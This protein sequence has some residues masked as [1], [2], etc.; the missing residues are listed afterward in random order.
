MSWED[1]GRGG[2]VENRGVERKCHLHGGLFWLYFSGCC[3]WLCK[4]ISA[5]SHL[6]GSLGTHTHTLQ[7]SE[8]HPTL[9]S[10]LFQNNERKTKKERWCD[11]L[12]FL[13]CLAISNPRPPF[14]RLHRSNPPWS[15]IN[16]S[17]EGWRDEK[18]RNEC[19]SD[20][21][22]IRSEAQ[23]NSNHQG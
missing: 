22:F 19:I 11:S 1:G 10:S 16:E 3:L 13:I 23:L 7:C 12:A 14:A 2:G 8:C 21:A 18:W 20:L 4:P 6:Q 5:G 17:A 9:H 15:Y